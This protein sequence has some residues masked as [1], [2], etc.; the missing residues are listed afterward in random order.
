[1]AMTML[2]TYEY[3]KALSLKGGYGNWLGEEYPV[4]EYV[5]P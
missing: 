5:A 4:T 1:M 3:L 2:W